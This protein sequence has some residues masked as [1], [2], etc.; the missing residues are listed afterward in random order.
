MVKIFIMIKNQKTIEVDVNLD[1]DTVSDLISKIK[2]KEPNIIFKLI[3]ICGEDIGKDK[4]KEKLSTFD[5][6][7]GDFVTITDY[8]AGD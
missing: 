2:S 7:E 1:K 3:T 4:Y 6:E 5:L 8:Y